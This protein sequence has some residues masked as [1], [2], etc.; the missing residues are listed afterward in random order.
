MYL[1]IV[2]TKS[3]QRVQHEILITDH[4]PKM[5]LIKMESIQTSSHHSSSVFPSRKFPAVCQNQYHLSI[6]FQKEQHSE[7]TLHP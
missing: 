2:H 7:N 6:T 5:H 4:L 3:Q 1:C